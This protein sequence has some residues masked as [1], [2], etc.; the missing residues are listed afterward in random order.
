MFS[1]SASK[2]SRLATAPIMPCTHLGAQILKH[3]SEESKKASWKRCYLSIVIKGE[4]EFVKQR[5]WRGRPYESEFI[6]ANTDADIGSFKQENNSLKGCWELTELL[7]GTKNHILG[8]MARSPA[9]NHVT[10]LV[11]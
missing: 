10:E 8:N 3:L 9:L 4:L 2:L 6:V 5:E 7:E 11:Q 1:V